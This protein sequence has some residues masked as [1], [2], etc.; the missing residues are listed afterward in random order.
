MFVDDVKNLLTVALDEAFVRYVVLV[1][2]YDHLR[3]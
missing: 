1:G 3:N 2:R